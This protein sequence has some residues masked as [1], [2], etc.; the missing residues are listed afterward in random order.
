MS[1]SE[2]SDGEKGAE[3]GSGDEKERDKE[4][5]GDGDKADAEDGDKEKVRPPERAGRQ[6]RCQEQLVGGSLLRFEW[7]NWTLNDKL[8]I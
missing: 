6:S 5:A 1:D 7:E 2:G 4:T 3:A 8:R